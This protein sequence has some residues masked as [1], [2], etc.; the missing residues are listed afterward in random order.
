MEIKVTKVGKSRISE[1]DFDNLGF[2]KVFTDHMARMRFDGEEWIDPQIVPFGDISISPAAVG[3]HYAEAVFEGAKGFR[4]ENEDIHLFRIMENIKRMNRS[5]KRMCIPQIPEDLFLE[6][7]VK[8]IKIDKDWIP[9][10]NGSALYIRPIIFGDSAFLGA[11]PSVTYRFLII[12]SPV[13]P[14]YKQGFNPISLM[15]SGK[16]VRAP[17][18]GTGWVKT[19]GNYAPALYPTAIAQKKGFAQVLWL[20][21]DGLIDE[22]GVMNIFF[23]D[24]E[25]GERALVTPSL[26]RGTILPG[27]TRASVIELAEKVLKMKVYEG[28]IYISGLVEAYKEGGL[29]EVFG[30]GTAAVISPVGIIQHEALKM[31][32]N[33]NQTG[34]ITK[35]LYD[36]LTG[37]QYGKIPDKFGWITKIK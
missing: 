5:N 9:K 10:S 4:A 15:T 18:G 13:G 14:Y 27:I 26:N 33:N 19:S 6:M 32:I 37:I 25:D 34:E 11:K 3:L 16:Y 35:T 30:T 20:N 17:E 2:G 7:L 1:V 23:V 24:E 21:K 28:D 22:G 31:V 29:K 8:L 12:L 36:L